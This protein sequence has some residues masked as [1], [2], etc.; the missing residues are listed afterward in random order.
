VTTRIALATAAEFADLDEDAPALL[1]AL[2]RLGLAGEAAVWTD[3]RIDWSAYDLVVVRSTWD[4]HHRRDEFVAWAERVAAVTRLANPAPV[5]RWNTDKTYLR[6]LAGAGLPVVPTEWLEPGDDF[7]VPE[8]GEY[9]VKPAVSAGS[10]DTN[11]YGAG[12]HDELAVAHVRALLAAGRTVMVQPYLDAVDTAG[13][14]ALLYVGDELSHA[15]RKG[16]LLTPAMEPVAGAYK[17]EEILPREPGPVERAVSEQV[18][19]ALAGVCPAGRA[20]L[21]FARVD[22]VPGSDGQPV[23]LELELTEPSLFLVHDGADGADAAARF[24]AAIAKAAG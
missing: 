11:R 5:V 9:V 10:K 8:H 7:V 6:A 23:L 21:L 1:A 18:L 20:D 19:D 3:P 13:E 16:P 22:L 17:E 24:A 14:T 2:S 12:D 15:V 4:Y